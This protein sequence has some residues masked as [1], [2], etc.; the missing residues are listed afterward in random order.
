[1]DQPHIAVLLPAYNAERY[2]TEAIESILDQ[3]Y[4][5]FDLF[6][7]NDGSTDKT[8]EI[9]KRYHDPRIK[10]IHN[11]CNMGLIATLNH[12]LD[13]IC[14]FDKYKYIARMDADDV[15]LPMRFEKQIQHMEHSPDIVV[16]GTSIQYF[17]KSSEKHTYYQS[18]LALKYCFLLSYGRFAHPSVMLRTK[19]FRDKK[20]RYNDAYKYAEDAELWAH[21]LRKE[22]ATNLPDVLHLYRWHGDNVSVRKKDEQ[23]HI[24]KKIVKE[25]FSFYLGRD[26]L[27]SETDFIQLKCDK[28]S[29]QKYLQFYN[30]IIDNIIQQDPEFVLNKECQRLI[31]ELVFSS[32]RCNFEHM[33]FFQGYIL[34]EKILRRKMGRSYSEMICSFFKKVLVRK[35]INMLSCI[36]RTRTTKNNGS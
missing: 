13:I 25:D 10:L 8:T 36:V 29:F 18:T 9:I 15:S 21:I 28:N 11:P 12:G 35:Y 34:I 32:I 4:P 16:C 5:H 1:M 17:D 24:A 31:E 7:I 2:I 20:Y 6:I 27:P 23:S 33:T 19:I 3:S 14:A 22:R 30:T 26:L